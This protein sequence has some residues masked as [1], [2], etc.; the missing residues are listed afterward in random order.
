MITLAKQFQLSEERCHQLAKS[1]VG[2]V[3]VVNYTD[4]SNKQVQK[5]Q[6]YTFTRFLGNKIK[7]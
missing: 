4:G 6:N 5:L 2:S 7:I 1:S 3:K